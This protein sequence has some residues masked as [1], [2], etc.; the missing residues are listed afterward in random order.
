[1]RD[2]NAIFSS[3]YA[4]KSAPRVML[5]RA[6]NLQAELSR[7]VKSF[8][9]MGRIMLTAIVVSG[10]VLDVFGAD[11]VKDASITVLLLP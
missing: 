2:H 1:M 9:V 11:Q 6:A 4:R 7:A 5:C 10:V 8:S 3:S